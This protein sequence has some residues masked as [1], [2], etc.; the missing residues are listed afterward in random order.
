MEI[1]R[2]VSAL[3]CIAPEAANKVEYIETGGG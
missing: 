3:F 1:I 2:T